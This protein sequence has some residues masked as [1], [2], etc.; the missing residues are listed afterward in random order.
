MSSAHA[1]AWVMLT[2]P[3]DLAEAV[4]DW[5]LDVDAPGFTGY[6]ISGHSG[7][8]QGLSLHEQVRGRRRGYQY[9]IEMPADAVAAF[10]E[11]L[12]AAFVGSR[13]RYAVLPVITAGKLHR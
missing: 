6:A 8:G 4:A 3:D 9:Q 5:L 13:I 2:V 1:T 11:Q 10:L 12:R 7:A